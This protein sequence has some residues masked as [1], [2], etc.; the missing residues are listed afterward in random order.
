MCETCTEMSD[1]GVTERIGNH[2]LLLPSVIILQVEQC[3]QC[4]Y[5]VTQ[6]RVRVTTVDVEKQQVLH[7]VVMCL[8]P[9]VS[10]M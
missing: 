9:L 10:S 5:N 3:R 1:F 4:T 7:I 8:Q 2:C 6:R